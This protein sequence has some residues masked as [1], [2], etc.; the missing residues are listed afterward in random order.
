MNALVNLNEYLRG[1]FGYIVIDEG[2]EDEDG[3]FFDRQLAK[4]VEEY[5]KEQRKEGYMKGFE[6][7]EN[8][9]G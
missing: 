7:G 2:L 9:D 4:Y 5:G 6:D 1:E 3:D 8:A